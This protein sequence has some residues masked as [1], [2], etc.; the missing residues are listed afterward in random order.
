MEHDRLLHR[1]I[2]H[3]SYCY[4][5]NSHNTTASLTDQETLQLTSFEKR[6]LTQTE[7]SINY[8]YGSDTKKEIVNIFAKKVDNEI[9]LFFVLKS[10]KIT[11][12]LENICDQLNDIL[13]KQNNT[14]SA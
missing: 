13:I 5:M 3:F 6:A 14:I 7:T 9:K 8:P 2:S 1:R 11:V 12:E 4:R 10:P